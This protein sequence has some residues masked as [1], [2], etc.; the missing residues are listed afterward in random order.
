MV[1]ESAYDAL[2]A[3]IHADIRWLGEEWL[4]EELAE[5]MPAE[6]ERLEGSLVEQC[7]ALAKA[8]MKRIT[9]SGGKG[10]TGNNEPKGGAPCGS[11][12]IDAGSFR[13]QDA[14]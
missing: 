12:S 11:D 1:W 5:S 8:W 14:G 10:V 3:G 6:C 4:R 9:D 13:R 7:E 2:S